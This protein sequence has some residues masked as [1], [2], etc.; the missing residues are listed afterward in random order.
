MALFV[1]AAASAVSTIAVKRE[2][3]SKVG[4]GAGVGAKV[5]IT[6]ASVHTVTAKR[7]K[8]LVL[9]RV[10]IAPVFL[11]HN[12]GGVRIAHRTVYNELHHMASFIGRGIAVHHDGV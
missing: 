3:G 1:V 6:Q 2:F 12:N 5:G 10:M 8:N 9:R 7:A 11:F 4:M